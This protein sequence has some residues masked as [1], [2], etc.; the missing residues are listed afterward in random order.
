MKVSIII[1]IYKVELEIN[2]CLLSVFKQDYLNLEVILVN[3]SSPDHSFD[4]AKDLISQYDWNDKAV[5]IS[6][7]VNR[8]L[9]I[10]R[11]SGLEVATGDYI[12]FLDSDD[13]LASPETISYLVSIAAKKEADVII[14]NFYQILDGRIIGTISMREMSYNSNEEIF[15]DY[16]K[17]LFWPTAWGKLIRREFLEDNALLFEEGIYHEDELWFFNVVRKAEKLEITPKIICQ[18]W[19]REESIM[20][21]ITEKHARDLN[22]IVREM[23]RAYVDNK[24]YYSLETAMVIERFRR[25][26]LERLFVFFDKEFIATELSV[27]K[28]IKLSPFSTGKTRYFKQN[29]LLRMPTKFI[30][31]YLALKWKS[32]L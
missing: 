7:E 15:S 25:S 1:P 24:S 13:E 28:V 3:D 31:W 32:K 2:R 9:S 21:S 22:F 17:S 14:G 23:Y 19:E 6:H 20:S 8:G 30:V 16:S 10:A 5:L 12:F 11:N 18:Y 26:A 29:I 27:L 4:I